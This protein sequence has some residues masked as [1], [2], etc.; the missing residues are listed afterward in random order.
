MLR[1][2]GGAETANRILRDIAAGLF[3]V[4][5]LTAE[6]HGLALTLQRRYAAF[7]LGLADLSVIVLAH[8]FRT[9]RILTFDQR[10]FRAVAPVQGGSFTILPTDER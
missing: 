5:S 7:D 4:V 2:R 9:R 3:E 10:H 6:E 8:R 1:K